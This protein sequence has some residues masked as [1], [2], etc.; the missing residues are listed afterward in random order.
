ML[1]RFLISIGSMLGFVTGGLDLLERFG[2][3]V[4]QWLAGLPDI[5]SGLFY[6]FGF[7]VDETA[8][9]IFGAP[10]PQ[11]SVR[12]QSTNGGEV[13]SLAAASPMITGSSDQALWISGA[14]TLMMLIILM[15]AMR[16][17]N[18]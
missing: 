6:R 18:Q 5:I 17:G 16:R 9:A 12:S 1:F 7:F 4:N 13:E 11:M 3:P 10:E 2:V 15:I 14:F 8:V